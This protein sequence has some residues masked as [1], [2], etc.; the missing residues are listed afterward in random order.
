[1]AH[2]EELSQITLEGVPRNE[3][4]QIEND[5]NKICDKILDDIKIDVKKKDGRN[6]NIQITFPKWLTN[7]PYAKSTVD[8]FVS[9]VTDILYEKYELEKPEKQVETDPKKIVNRVIKDM[10]IECKNKELILTFPMWF[11]H[12]PYEKESVSQIID[13]ITK[14]TIDQMNKDG[15]NCT[16]HKVVF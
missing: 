15:M 2:I 4:N 10:K 8:Q 9:L 7:G 3:Q 16:S 6:I 5:P 14:Q 1:M 12:G 13:L 11:T